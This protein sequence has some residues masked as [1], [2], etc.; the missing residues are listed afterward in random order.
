MANIFDNPKYID[1]ISPSKNVFDSQD[2]MEEGNSVLFGENQND[3]REQKDKRL[4]KENKK[5]WEDVLQK[6]VSETISEALVGEKAEWGLYWDRGIGASLVNQMSTY[7]FNTELGMN[8]AEAL[9]PE[10]DDTGIGE[11]FF[12]SIATLIGDLPAIAPAVAATFRT[13]NPFV[14]GYSAGFLTESLKK[15]YTTA[16]QRGDVDNFSQWWDIFIEDGLEAGNKAGLQLG[17]A[18]QMPGLVGA[19]GYLASLATQYLSYQGMGLALNQQMPSKET[20]INDALLFSVFNLGNKGSTVA[21]N[22]ANRS[23]KTNAEIIKDMQIDPTKYADAVAINT[24][25]FRVGDSIKNV[26]NKIKEKVLPKKDIKDSIVI[27]VDFTKSI[28]EGQ[29]TP[30]ANKSFKESRIQAT[31][32]LQESMLDFYYPIKSI[33]KKFGETDGKGPLNP[34]EQFRIEPGVIGRSYEYFE[35]TPLNFALEPLGI[36]NINTILKDVN[37]KTLNDLN[38]VGE[39]LI[40]LRDVELQTR[41]KPVETGF[42]LNKSKEIVKNFEQKYGKEFA[43]DYNKITDAYLEY[44]YEAGLLSKKS[45]ELIKEANR[46]YTP[47]HT[48]RDKTTTEIGSGTKGN[49]IRNPYNPIKKIKKRKKGEEIQEP[50]LQNPIDTTY[51][52]I[53]HIIALAEKNYATTKLIEMFERNPSLAKSLGIEKAKKRTEVTEVTIKELSDAI[54]VDKNIIKDAGVENFLVFRKKDVLTNNQIAIYRNGVREVWNVPADVA[55]AVTGSNRITSNLIAD[56]FT[57]PTKAL[58]LGITLSPAFAVRNIIRDGMVYT[59]VRRGGYQLPFWRTIQGIYH[60]TKNTEKY[61]EF[62]RS[63]AMQSTLLRMDRYFEPG[64]KAEFQSRT[65]YNEFGKRPVQK[66]VELL[67]TI[68]DLGEQATKV[69]DFIARIKELEKVNTMN[70]RQKLERAGFEARDI[71]DFAKQGTIGEVANRY[72]AFFTARLRGYEKLYES[73][74]ER[75]VR[76]TATALI[77]ITVPSVLLALYNVHDPAYGDLADWRKD[78]FWNIPLHKILGLEDPFFLSLP[79]PW[80]LGI[81]FGSIPERIIEKIYSD[82][83]VSVTDTMITLS[84]DTLKQNAFVIPDIIRQGVEQ[85]TNKSIFFD[86]PI[87]SEKYKDRTPDFQYDRRS[88]EVAKFLG[89]QF[90]I[91]AFRTDYFVSSMTGAIGESII[92]FTDKILEVSGVVEIEENFDP[93][94][95]DWIK[96]LDQMYGFKSFVIRQPGLSSSHLSKLWDNYKE[97]EKVYNSLNAAKSEANVDKIIQYSN[98]PKYIEYKLMKPTIESIG[99]IKKVIDVIDN[100]PNFKLNE[101]QIKFIRN[102]NTRYKK[103]TGKDIPKKQLKKEVL[104]EIPNMPK[105]IADVIIEDAL[106]GEGIFSK[107]LPDVNEKIEL[108]D[109]FFQIMIQSAKDTNKMIEEFRNPKKSDIIVEE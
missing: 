84:K 104:N 109:I 19:K 59:V 79:K 99:K 69:G 8:W 72:T 28:V 25:K 33:V 85:Y 100:L 97:T 70:Y 64:V 66:V 42:D 5:Y 41:K 105:S 18:L 39:Y 49:K 10:P 26:V 106:G 78:L 40:R 60:I 27:D 50:K 32:A 35:G 88:S 44:A 46:S 63:G 53:V 80:E 12:G 58:R 23:G 57:I 107:F 21:K 56:L 73:F 48:I 55:R 86:R 13:G 17:V 7:H 89:R 24:T 20:L 81:I 77:N 43:K 67:K 1:D 101:E 29:K 4:H 45:L 15:T 9:G 68:G 6:N 103:A 14:I 61:K 87:V 3:T 92:K 37:V 51:K 38:A 2:M 96:N 16:L 22:E 54:G 74:S 34:Y 36:K 93:W 62:L 102:I 90:D 82:D 98:D 65:I 108:K 30:G 95:K 11:R 75:P 31:D 47:W 91:P 71:F 94:S 76:A 52:N 83:P